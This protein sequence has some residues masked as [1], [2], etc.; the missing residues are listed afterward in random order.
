MAGFLD[1][2]YQI[3]KIANLIEE[4]SDGFLTDLKQKDTASPCLYI[5]WAYAIRPYIKIIDRR[6]ACPLVFLINFSYSNSH[7]INYHEIPF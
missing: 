5:N 7:L 2:M 6:D 1:M 4:S 3:S